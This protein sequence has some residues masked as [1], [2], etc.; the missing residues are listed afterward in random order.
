[1]S[2]AG[3]VGELKLCYNLTMFGMCLGFS[4]NIPP[5]KR[6]VCFDKERAR[7]TEM[8]LCWRVCRSCLVFTAF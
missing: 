6:E 5:I 7:I 4:L 1:M 8:K 3:E 2:C